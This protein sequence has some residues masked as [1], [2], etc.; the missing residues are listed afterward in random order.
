MIPDKMKALAILEPG[1]AQVVEVATPA[2]LPG[3]VLIKIERCLLCTWE[4][5]MYHNGAGATLPMIPG[6]EISGSIAAV[7]EGTITSFQ[8]GDRVVGKTL[9]SC[10]HC[11]YCYS[12]DDNNCVGLAKKRVYD[13]IPSSGGLAQFIALPISRVYRLPDQSV[14]LNIAAF[15]EPLACCIR[16]L[17]RAN[18]A[19]GEDAVIVG[20]GIMGQLHN[21]LV[22]LRGGRSIV[23]DLDAQRLELAKKMGADEVINPDGED[24]V[25]RIKELTLGMGAH[26]IFYTLRSP[27][28]AQEYLQALRKLGRMVYYGSFSP[29]DPIQVDPNAI[30]YTEQVI[31]G[32]YSPTSKG[33]YTAARLLSYGLIYVAPFLSGVYP[34][35]EAA[36]ALER[37]MAPD[38]FRVGIDLWA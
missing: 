21:L 29:K 2:P 32:A 38:T 19:L 12:G 7:P 31:T 16:S 17:D 34:L 37:S 18:L 13:G 30:H 36:T 1:K 27:T 4:Q 24:P 14:D 3:E 35:H 9:D 22:K 28:L 20:A 6:H 25:A 23:V 15:A 11:E 33:F 10:G 5:R 26:A 8:V